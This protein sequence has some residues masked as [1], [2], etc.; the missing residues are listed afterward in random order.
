MKGHD[1]SALIKINQAKTELRRGRLVYIFKF[2]KT[3]HV[4][5]DYHSW[6]HTLVPLGGA[7]YTFISTIN[8][9]AENFCCEMAY[10]DGYFSLYLAAL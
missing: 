5:V 8:C 2:P 1:S 10:T 4:V 6:K 3:S 7:H 9:P